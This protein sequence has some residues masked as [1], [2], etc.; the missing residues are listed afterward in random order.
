MVL[1]IKNFDGIGVTAFASGQ[2]DKQVG[3]NLKDSVTYCI[4]FSLSL[5]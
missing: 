1:K 5:H 4:E 2:T 3:Y